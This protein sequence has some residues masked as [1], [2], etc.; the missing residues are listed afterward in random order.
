MKPTVRYRIGF[1]DPNDHLYDIRIT[2]VAKGT[3]TLTLPAWR[4]GR[5]LIQNYAANV[6]QWSASGQGGRPLKVTKTAKSSWRVAARPGE[7]VE[8]SYHFYAGVLDAGSSWLAAEEAYFNGS[9]LFM[10]VAGRREDPVSLELG[11]PRSWRIISQLESDKRGRFAAR[12]YDELIDSPFLCS[13]N[14]ALHE[15]NESGCRIR[16]AFQGARGMRTAQLARPVR[17]IVAAHSRLFGGIPTHRY[18]FLYH[19]GDRWHGV[20]HASSSSIVADRW[21]ML[22][23]KPGEEAWEHFLAITSHE[24]FHLWNVKRILPERFAPYDYST[25]TPTGLLWLM[26]GVTSYYGERMLLRSGLWSAERYLEH[27][28]KEIRILEAIPASRWLSLSQAS[29][30]AWLQEPAQMHDKANAWISFYNKGEIVAALLDLEIRRRTRGGKSLDDVMRDLWKR[31]GKRGKGLEE[32]A[33]PRAVERITKSD[34]SGFFASYV[35][36]V[37]PLPYEELLPLAGVGV[38]RK[39][40]AP[41]SGV[42][43]KENGGRLTA[44]SVRTGS[45]AAKGGVIAGDELIAIGDDRVRTA[46]EAE[47]LWQQKSG[48]GARKLLIA[49][50]RQIRTLKVR[51]RDGRAIEITLRVGGKADAALRGWLARDE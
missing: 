32:D 35:D 37:E 17:A 10:M 12:D 11:V 7:P 28:T 27:L 20:E 31:Y 36:G 5:Y 18:T 34:F 44:D 47:R 38:E 45:A 13:P 9:N 29:F 19:L 24:F 4:P 14:V 40:A 25:E 21:E 30:D 3:T 23:A 48:P 39:Q 50:N 1:D 43:W 6:R 2:F 42:K 51:P 16:L 22:G 46:K 41:T 33:M 49:R 8:V 15:F 26:E